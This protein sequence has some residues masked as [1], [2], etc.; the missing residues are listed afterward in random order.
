MGPANQ[1]VQVVSESLG[2][3]VAWGNRVAQAASVA[4]DQQDVREA[5][6]AQSR[7]RVR[8]ERLTWTPATAPPRLPETAAP[9]GGETTG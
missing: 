8:A 1:A 7:R 6:L 5:E 3:R 2:A 4:L 9:A